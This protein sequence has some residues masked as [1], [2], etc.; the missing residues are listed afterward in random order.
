MMVFLSAYFNTQRYNK[1]TQ[2]IHTTINFFYEQV[3]QVDNIAQ[4]KDWIHSIVQQHSK[5]IGTLNYIFCN[6]EY[7]LVI[8]QKE[9]QHNTYTD[10]ISFDYAEEPNEVTGDIYIST[11]RV[12][13]NA[14]TYNASFRNELARV[15]IHGVLHL[16]GYDD[17]GAEAKLLMR[18]QEDTALHHALIQPFLRA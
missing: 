8:N 5:H 18:S 17:H 11:Q 6:D 15:M 14:P 1:M 13:E 7:L 12:A 3:E 9:L 4:T 2:A 16:L 10:V